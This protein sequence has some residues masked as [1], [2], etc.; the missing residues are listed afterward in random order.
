MSDGLYRQANTEDMPGFDGVVMEQAEPPAEHRWVVPVEFDYAKER[1]DEAV[2]LVSESISALSEVR[3]ALADA[4]QV[5]QEAGI[6]G[7]DE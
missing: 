2:T 5:W 4:L 3:T 7:D 6:G 1:I